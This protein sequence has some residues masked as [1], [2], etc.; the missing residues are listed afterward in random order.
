MYVDFFLSSHFY[1]WTQ[2]TSKWWIWTKRTTRQKCKR[3]WHKYAKWTPERSQYQGLSIQL[4]SKTTTNFSNCTFAFCIASSEYGA[5]EDRNLL[6]WTWTIW[7]HNRKLWFVGRV[8]LRIQYFLLPSKID[9]LF[10]QRKA[11]KDYK[12]SLQRPVSDEVLKKTCKQKA[13]IDSNQ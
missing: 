1:R 6:S 11:S 4:S 10:T 12:R 7:L 2:Q 5:W 8:L 3:P 13:R 9:N